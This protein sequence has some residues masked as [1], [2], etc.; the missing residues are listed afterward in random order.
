ME[1]VRKPEKRPNPLNTK[2]TKS[3][4]YGK[5][6]ETR[7]VQNPLNT[8]N[9]GYWRRWHCW[10]CSSENFDMPVTKSDA[11][12]ITKVVNLHGAIITSYIPHTISINCNHSYDWN[13]LII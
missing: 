13:I 10:I 6:P 7:K 8:E 4:D 3:R 11:F 1:S 2:I 9:S 12:V 5:C